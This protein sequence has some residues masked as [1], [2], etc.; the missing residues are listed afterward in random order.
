MELAG[1]SIIQPKVSA[2][3]GRV[4]NLHLIS[5]HISTWENAAFWWNI[6]YINAASEYIHMVQSKWTNNSFLVLC[7]RC[8]ILKLKNFPGSREEAQI[9][10]DHCHLACWGKGEESGGDKIPWVAIGG[11]F[12]HI[13]FMFTPQIGEDFHFD[14]HIFQRGWLKPPT[15][16]FRLTFLWRGLRFYSNPILGVARDGCGGSQLRIYPNQLRSLVFYGS[17]WN[18]KCRKR[19]PGPWFREGENHLESSVGPTDQL[20]CWFFFFRPRSCLD[21]TATNLHDFHGCEI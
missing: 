3:V 21:L 16:F 1:F 7:G 5:T 10:I 17:P 13:F 11:G 12:S 9:D 18:Q 15:R 6:H 20:P 19:A 14:S 4:L 2:W 8:G